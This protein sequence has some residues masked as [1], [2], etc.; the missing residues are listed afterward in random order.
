MR[1]NV[2]DE[3]WHTITVDFITDLH[4]TAK[5]HDAILTCVDKLTKMCHLLPTT[6]SLTAEQC[7][8]LMFDGVFKHHGWPQVIVSDRGKLFTSKFWEALHAH[9]GTVLARSSAYHPQTDGQ[10]ERYNRIVEDMLRKYVSPTLDDWDKWL[11]CA[12]FAINNSFVKSIGTTPFYV[13]YGRHPTTPMGMAVTSKLQEVKTG[14]AAS[15][16]AQLHERIRTQVQLF[17]KKNPVAPRVE[18]FAKQLQDGVG[19]AR[20]LLQAARDRMKATAD[21]TR[22]DVK[23]VVGQQVLLSSKHLSF[24]GRTS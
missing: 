23:F 8:W 5:G 15:R 22:A 6:K 24:K 19:R 16:P 4:G 1:V 14:V 12:E 21:K 11:P 20:Q 13:N 7:A 18:L 3:L 10:T 17:A 2:P 9:N